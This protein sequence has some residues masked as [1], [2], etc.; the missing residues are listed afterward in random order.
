[1]E[2]FKIVR[3]FQWPAHDTEC[4]EVVFDTFDTD[5][6]IAMSLCKHK[7]TVIQAGG[8]CGVWASRFAG[9]FKSVL[10]FEPDPLNYACLVANTAKLDNVMTFPFALGDHESVGVSIDV[11]RGNCGAGQISTDGSGSIAM[12]VMDKYGIPD[13]D[14]IYLDVEGFE[15][16][17]LQGMEKTIRRCQPVVAFEDK[18]LS[19]RYGV[20]KGHAEKWMAQVCGYHVVTRV[21]RDVIMVP[22]DA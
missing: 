5:A 17:A 13:V 15:L 9:H 4:A 21:N 2:Q 18:G 1:M 6:V 16:S 14:L 12:V 19:E 20:P 11:P 10:T 7:R 22:K 8:N 3:G